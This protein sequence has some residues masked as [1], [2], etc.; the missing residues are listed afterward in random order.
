MPSALLNDG[1]K[2]INC[3]ARG[4][5]TILDDGSAQ[6]QL[7]ELRSGESRGSSHEPSLRFG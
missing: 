2:P 4:T 7:Q 1:D 6:L 5:H 3:D